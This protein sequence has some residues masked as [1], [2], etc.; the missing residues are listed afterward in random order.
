MVSDSF[1][2]F[3]SADCNR[4]LVRQDSSSR[5]AGSRV[6]FWPGWILPSSATRFWRRYRGQGKDRGPF[7]SYYGTSAEAER[8]F[9]NYLAS[10]PWVRRIE[11]CCVVSTQTFQINDV[12]LCVEHCEISAE[13][14]NACLNPGA[15]S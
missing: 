3:Q 15:V 12:P 4:P 11:G 6:L 14:L 10:P 13:K 2:D 7:L 5:S 9:E 8:N 1:A